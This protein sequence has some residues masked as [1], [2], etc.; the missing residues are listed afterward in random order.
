MTKVIQTQ[1]ANVTTLIVVTMFIA[2]TPETAV[3]QYLSP[4]S[5]LSLLFI[6]AIHA[7]DKGLGMT[8]VTSD[9]VTLVTR[10][11]SKSGTEGADT[12]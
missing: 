9:A 4:M 11:G 12:V 10:A 3:P 7:R 2:V 5:P 6:L 8:Y 1:M